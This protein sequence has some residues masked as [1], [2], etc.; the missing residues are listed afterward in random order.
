MRRP[1][2]M[3]LAAALLGCSSNSPPPPPV[4]P[5]LPDDRPDDF[6]LAATIFSPNVAHEARLPR[7]LRPA[8]YIVEPDGS[9]RAAI[10]PGADATTYPGRT[11]QLTPAQFDSLWRNVRQSGLLDP[12][13]P[14]REDDPEVLTR[15]TDR[16]TA[17]VYVGFEGRRITLRIL[18]DRTSPGSVEAEKL[19]DRLAEWAW[20]K[21]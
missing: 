2:I 13:N 5:P 20:I 10:G 9:L 6:V 8:R 3:I 16:T 7:S 15:S 1:L 11:R 18:M 12:D 19:I 21:D 17:L 4:E 14:S